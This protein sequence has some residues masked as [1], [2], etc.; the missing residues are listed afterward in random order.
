MSEKV[1]HEAATLERL[2]KAQLLDDM[3]DNAEV[4]PLLLQAIKKHN[5]KAR[6]PELDAVSQVMTAITPHLE[7]I[8]K[9]K[10]ELAAERDNFRA[11][12]IRAKAQKELNLNDDQFKEVVEH[13]KTNQIGDLKVATEHWEMVK[14]AA[15]PRPGPDTSIHLP[16]FKGLGENPVQWARDEARR[17]LHEFEIAKKRRR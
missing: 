5:P 8:G 2:Q 14:A 3:Y 4:Q 12:Q 10:Q 15:E 17:T 6:I 11:E 16:N 7:E 1:T 13:A 9:T